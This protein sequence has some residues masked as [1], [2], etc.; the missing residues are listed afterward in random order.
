MYVNASNNTLLTLTLVHTYYEKSIPW[1]AKE[2]ED[3]KRDYPKSPILENS[4]DFVTYVKNWK[5][6]SWRHCFLVEFSIN[7]NSTVPMAILSEDQLDPIF[8][9]MVYLRGSLCPGCT[10]VWIA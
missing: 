6:Q 10:L 3:M 8:I 4:E 7:V 9:G 5:R 1:A 2:L